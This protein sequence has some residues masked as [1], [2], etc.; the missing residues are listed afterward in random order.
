M[1]VPLR[2]LKRTHGGFKALL[3]CVLC[4]IGFGALASER[5]ATLGY[6]YSHPADQALSG[7]SFRAVNQFHRNFAVE[8]TGTYADGSGRAPWGEVGLGATLRLD[9]AREL[10]V[11]NTE[12]VYGYL[13]AYGLYHERDEAGYG[14]RLNAGMDAEIFIP[15]LFFEGGIQ[16]TNLDGYHRTGLY[17]QFM[18]DI[19]RTWGVGARFDVQKTAGWQFQVRRRF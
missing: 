15:G 13:R 9:L 6:V 1:V 5:H 3:A 2:T 7:A 17:S 12:G 4:T 16:Y 11:I 8:T 18:V 19:N 14:Y 10:A